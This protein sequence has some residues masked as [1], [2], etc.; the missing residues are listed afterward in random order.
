MDINNNTNI[1]SQI[2]QSISK[3]NLNTAQRAFR[4]TEKSNQENSQ[5]IEKIKQ[6][7]VAL[8]DENDVKAYQKIIN[9]NINVRCASQYEILEGLL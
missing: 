3:L 7:D 4:A 6:E 9:K 8:I 1:T 5:E 2:A